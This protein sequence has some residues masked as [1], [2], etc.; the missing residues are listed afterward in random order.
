M[1]KPLHGFRAQDV[2]LSEAVIE[3]ETAKG[4]I[5][6]PQQARFMYSQPNHIPLPAPSIKRIDRAVEPFEYGRVYG[7]FWDMVIEH[8]GLPFIAWLGYDHLQLV[9]ATAEHAGQRSRGRR[10]RIFSG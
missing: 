9:S 10:T 5:D 4:R 6:G 8:A 3:D 7:V 2:G 1:L